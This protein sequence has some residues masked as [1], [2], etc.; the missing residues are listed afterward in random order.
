MPGSI[1]DR[2]NCT[3]GRNTLAIKNEDA[4]QGH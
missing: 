3:Y 1:Y 2:S 4:Q